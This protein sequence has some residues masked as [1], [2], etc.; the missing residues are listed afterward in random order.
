MRGVTLDDRVVIGQ[1]FQRSIEFAGPLHGPHEP[2]LLVE[3]RFAHRLGHRHGLGLLVVVAQDQARNL[4]GHGREQLVS[5]LGPQ[6]AA[7]N[8]VVQQ[9]LNVHFVVRCVDTGGIVDGIGVDFSAAESELDAG[10]LGEAEICAFAHHAHAE[11]G[12]MR[13][14]RPEARF[15]HTRARAPLARGESH[16]AI[17][18]LRACEAQESFGFRNPNVLAWRSTLALAA[19]LRGSRGLMTK[20]EAAAISVPVLIAVGTADEI[21]GSATA[22][23][24]IIPGSEVL[25]IPNR[26]HMRAVGDKVYKAGVAEFLSARP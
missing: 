13:G 14:T 3:H 24:K 22:L 15:L 21:A 12:Q 16:A 4:I 18:D 10:A 9:D 7:F 25:D 8:G 17:A 20:Q 26:D 19:C 11:L 1:T 6:L 5:I 23:G 2:G